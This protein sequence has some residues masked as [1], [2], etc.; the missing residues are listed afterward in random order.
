MRQLMRQQEILAELGVV[1]LQGIPFA[2]LL[3]RTVKLMAAG[4]QAEFCKVMEYLPSKGV[5][6]IRAGCGWDA[7]VIG[8]T[9]GADLASP[10]GFALRTGK[11][12]I[13]NHLE[14]EDR[15]RTPSLLAKYGIRRAMN[16]I[17]KGDGAPFGVLE[18]DSRSPGE[19]SLHDVAFLQ[20]AANILGT[21]IEKQRMERDLQAA[22]DTQK[23][24]LAELNHRIKNSL[25][26]VASM[27]ALQAAEK[28]EARRDLEDAAARVHAIARAHESLYRG[29]TVQAIDLGRYLADICKHLTES[30]GRCHLD[31]ATPEGVTISGDTAVPIALIV[32]ELITNTMKHA[33]RDDSGGL[34]M[35]RMERD[36]KNIAIRIRDQGRG[37]PPGFDIGT[38]KGV[39]M[40]IIRALKAQLNATITARAI[41]PG[42]EFVLAVPIDALTVPRD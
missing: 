19:F 42:T 35:L 32:N 29:T 6:L 34:I 22:V 21:A 4:L 15:F 33:Y 24:L 26:L 20:G 41:G 1:A 12:V 8:A 11:P 9:F 23:I 40:S 13:S 5:F 31:I 36:E 30:F 39:G 2:E 27:L 14:H 38:K 37:L 17:L 7:E 10:A 25:Q 3:E 28:G 18:V 16:V